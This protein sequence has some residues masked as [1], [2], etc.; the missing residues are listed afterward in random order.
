[1]PLALQ[2]PVLLFR[3]NMTLIATTHARSVPPSMGLHSV[4]MACAAASN[5][6]ATP[7]STAVDVAQ[8]RQLVQQLEKQAMDAHEQAQAFNKQGRFEEA[9]A[10][11]AEMRRLDAAALD[12]TQALG[13]ASCAQAAAAAA[14]GCA[15]PAGGLGT[16]QRAAGAVVGCCVADAAATP[17]Q[18]IYDVQQ[19]QQ[20]QQQRQ[21]AAGGAPA[22]GLVGL[23][24][25]DPVQSSFLPMYTTGRNSPYGEQTLLLLQSLAEQ[26]GLNC[27]SYA[28]L[29]A[30]RYGNGFDG[31]MN[32]STVAFLRNR[33]RGLQPPRTGA[34]DQQADCVARLAPLVAMYAGDERLMSLVEAATRT[35][36]NTD[37]AAA[38]GCAGAAV[39][40][41][42]LLGQP[43]GQAVKETVQELKQ[44][45]Q[46]AG[47]M[48]DAEQAASIAGHLEKALQL[49]QTPHAD[50][51]QELGRNCHMPN[52][53]QTP[54]HAVLHHEWLAARQQD[55]AG[56]AAH[57]LTVEARQ[58]MFV[59]A[60]RDVMLAG[61]CCASRASYAGACLGAL[62]GP[63]AVPASWVQRCDAGAKV[64]QWAAAVCA[65]R[66]GA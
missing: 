27:S 49:Q 43:A 3:N 14:A 62:L 4:V 35:T 26:A 51:V 8:G 56:T 28:A 12:A 42:L 45:Q 58:G 21:Q 53:L 39:L 44:Q 66:S 10:K 59:A 13:C 18:W 57:G 61:G 6:V 60:L 23:E 19:L 9:Q 41:R 34:E 2:R 24:F 54:I 40:E 17:V 63:E 64:Q 46:G 52:A 25:Y 20:L 15:D 16:A 48:P 1:M 33:A 32:A 5:S 38:W 7:T 55:G 65:A 36:Q 37:A 22:A 11:Y 29:Y 30:A 31:Y 50:A 47:R